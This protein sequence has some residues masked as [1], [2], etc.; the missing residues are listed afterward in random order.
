MTRV[1]AGLA[2]D[3]HLERLRTDQ[4]VL[5]LRREHVEVEGVPADAQRGRGIVTLS[6][7]EL[8]WRSTSIRPDVSVKT[9]TPSSEETKQSASS[10]V[11][12]SW[13]EASSIAA[14]RPRRRRRTSR[15]PRRGAGPARTGSACRLLRDT[16]AELRVGGL[17][18]PA[19]A[20]RCPS[21]EVLRDDLA[22]GRP[23]SR[24]RPW[25]SQRQ[26]VGERR[27]RAHVVADEQHRP[28]LAARPRPSCR[29]TSAG[30][31][32]RR[33][34]APRRRSGSPARGARR[35]R[36]RAAGTCRSSSA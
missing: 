14:R 18:T 36:T 7:A 21:R 29:G 23:S 5:R 1:A 15:R 35:R 10:R 13:S 30:T 6:S 26:R 34:R 9:S 28:A 4:V 22:S 8:W 31:R 11:G 27:D 24:T 17:R 32:R 12:R 3:D 16:L 20:G 19:A 25:S 2:R 33:P